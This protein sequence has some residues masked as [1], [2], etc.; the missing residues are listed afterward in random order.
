MNS[1][2]DTLQRWKPVNINDDYICP[3][4]DCLIGHITDTGLSL[5]DT[6]AWLLQVPPMS[7]RYLGQQRVFDT[8]SA[9]NRISREGPDSGWNALL[10]GAS[11]GNRRPRTKA[12]W[13]TFFATLSKIPQHLREQTADLNTLFSGC[14]T[15]WSDPGWPKIAANLQDLNEVFNNLAPDNDPTVHEALQRIKQFISNASYHQIANLVE[16]FHQALID[17][18][19]TLDES[20]PHAQTDSLT[21]W[22][23]LLSTDTP[24]VCPN[25]LHIIELKCPADLDAEHRALGHCIQSYDY[26]AYR[27]NCRLISV[28]LD[29]QSLA[30][31]ELQL[32]AD[33]EMPAK[34][35]TRHL[36]TTQLRGRGNQLPRSGSRVERAYQW[37]WSQVQTGAIPVNLEWPD[38]THAMPRYAR[39]NRKSLHARA[40]AEWINERLG[41]R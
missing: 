9:L 2:W 18:R 7:V 32:T 3:I 26:S 38:M 8:G 36:E 21:C 25:G 14:P 1:P 11:L 5:I 23:P 10:V 40:C 33:E 30:S 20:D 35:N 17:I 12:H 41:R 34:W 24:I 13:K 29:G 4:N 27:G 37:F 39:R 19:I 28:R 6:L 15:D 16:G 22:S 31:A